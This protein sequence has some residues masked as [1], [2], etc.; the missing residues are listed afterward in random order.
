[1]SEAD[2]YTRNESPPHRVAHRARRLVPVFA[3]I[4]VLAA[5]GLLLARETSSG[6]GCAGE[7]PCMLYFYKDT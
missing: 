6:R 4:L 2:P 7:G 3:A 5:G 1:M